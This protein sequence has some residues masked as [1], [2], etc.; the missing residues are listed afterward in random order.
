MAAIRPRGDEIARRGQ[1][2]YEQKLRR[3]VES[4]E[5]IG[6]LISIDVDSEDFAISD[7]LLKSGAMVRERHPEARLYGARIGY[8]A[9]YGIGGTIKRTA[10]E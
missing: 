4:P 8:N 5:N 2:I 1:E 9:V 7:D 6:K 10:P 3:L